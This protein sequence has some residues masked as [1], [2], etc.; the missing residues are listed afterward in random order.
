[1]SPFLWATLS[2]QKN[3]TE[4]PNVA[5]TVDFNNSLNLA[6]LQCQ[7]PNFCYSQAQ[8]GFI[9]NCSLKSL[10]I[11]GRFKMGPVSLHFCSSNN[12]KAL[13]MLIGSVQT[14]ATTFSRLTINRTTLGRATLL[15][16][17][18]SRAT[19]SRLILSKELL[20][21]EKAQYS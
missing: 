20:L 21:K 10:I 4:L 19:L 15:K 11:L 6:T 1:M 13:N 18:L 14:C 5:E 8:G 2:L 12:K 17:K 7:N 16:A 9:V 3:H